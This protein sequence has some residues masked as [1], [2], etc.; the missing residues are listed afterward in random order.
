MGDSTTIPVRDSTTIPVGDSK[1]ILVEDS[2][3][4]PV[5]DS[6]TIPELILM[7]MANN[8]FEHLFIDEFIRS[9]HWDKTEEQDFQ[10]LIMKVKGYFWILWSR[11]NVYSTKKE[12]YKHP[13]MDT[14]K[15][16]DLIYN[17]RN[18]KKI[19]DLAS[20]LDDDFN[21]TIKFLPNIPHGVQPHVIE[22]RDFQHSL[23]CIEEAFKYMRELTTESVLFVIGGYDFDEVDK[24][25]AMKKSIQRAG[26]TEIG[27]YLNGSS[28]VQLNTPGWSEYLF[29]KK[30][31][32]MTRDNTT[33]GFEWPSI[34]FFYAPDRLK[35]ERTIYP[36][37][38]MHNQIL[39]CMSNF[40]LITPTEKN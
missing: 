24:Y 26:E 37:F 20:S 6:K 10:K 19:G 11:G 13:L 23:Q 7:Y 33:G 38:S 28:F 39:R 5:G 17:M 1:T 30:G 12:G 8:S 40:I 27:V 35:K 29:Q 36:E 16:F 31:V 21:L 34:I 22:Y 4:I 25:K 2:K 15:T 14:F 18:S 3:T 9:S 32:L